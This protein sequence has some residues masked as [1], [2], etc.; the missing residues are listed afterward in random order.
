MLGELLVG[1]AEAAEVAGLIGK[2]GF[3]DHALGIARVGLGLN[4]RC[5]RGAC[6]ECH[7]GC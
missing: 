2:G 4:R 1:G 7:E 3:V 6:W 5:G